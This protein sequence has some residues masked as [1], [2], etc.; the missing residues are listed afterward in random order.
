MAKRASLRKMESISSEYWWIYLELRLPVG[1][2]GFRCGWIQ[3]FRVHN[4]SLFFSHCSALLISVSFSDRLFPYGGKMTPGVSNSWELA[5]SEK[6]QMHC[7]M[8]L[9]PLYIYGSGSARCLL[10]FLPET[11]SRKEIPFPSCFMPWEAVL[12]GP[13]MSS[14]HWFLGL[15]NGEPWQ[16]IEGRKES[17]FKVFMPS[18]PSLRCSH[19]LAVSLNW[20]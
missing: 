20:R 1:F 15:A 10:C 11:L 17:E 13:Q 7:P 14:C 4:H 3:G 19:V 6:Q 8:C 2:P 5:D 18:A 16:D 9:R 12:H